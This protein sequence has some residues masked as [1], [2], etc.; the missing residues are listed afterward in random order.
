[1]SVG[2]RAYDMLRG[3]VNQEWERIQGVDLDQA[4]R[5]LDAA[6]D[7]P[8]PIGEKSSTPPAPPMDPK[9]RAR[10]ILGVN[11]DADFTA[12]RQAF[13]KL[14]TRSDP[15]K[16]PESSTERSQAS[17]IQKRVCWAYDQLTD[18]MD[19]TEVRFKSLEID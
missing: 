19:A 2:K 9:E 3:Y 17:D 10:Q 7:M 16:F 1:M 15:T 4:K 12:I 13:E 18:G 5:E 6:M 11:S 8:R 14:N